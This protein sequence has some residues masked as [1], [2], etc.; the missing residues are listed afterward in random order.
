MRRHVVESAADRLS[1]WPYAQPAWVFTHRTLPEVVGAD[2]ILD[3]W[4]ALASGAQ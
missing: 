4:A 3:T 1:A 2:I